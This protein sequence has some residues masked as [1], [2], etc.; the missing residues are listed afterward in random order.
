MRWFAGCLG[1]QRLQTEYMRVGTV[2]QMVQGDTWRG[3]PVMDTIN[4]KIISRLTDS[5]NNAR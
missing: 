2:G 3:H 1:L 4:Q 5:E